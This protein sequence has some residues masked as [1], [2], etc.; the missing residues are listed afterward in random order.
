M[1]NKKAVGIIGMGY[2]V[3]EKILTNQDLEKIVDTSNEWIVERTGVKER[4]IA[5]ENEATSDLAIKASLEALKNANVLADELDLVIVA[6]ATQDMAFPSVACLVQNAIGAKRAAAFDLTAGC[7]GFVY[8][9]VTASQFIQNGLYK[10]ILI[11]GS[12]TLSKITNWEDRNTCVLF[13]DGA[14]A[15]VVSEVDEG[16][17]LLGCELGANGGGGDLLKLPAGGSR[18]PAS[19]ETI[20]NK[21]HYIHMDGNEV[22]KFAIKIMGEAALKS[23]ERAGLKPEDID[24]LVPHQANNRIILSAAKKLK[25]PME[26]VLVN[27]ERYGNTS[28]ASIPIVMNEALKD[29][30]IKKGTVLT[31]VGFGAG[32]TWAACTMR[33]AV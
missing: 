8:A 3:P 7:S 12:E 22:F 16:F 28:A 30:R 17:G 4:R 5:S 15:A 25:M 31:L 1:T 23:I 21:E 26:K 29:G 6:T 11:I 32:L 13:G 20:N 14:G 33:W 2:Y 9:F 18:K 24:L 19:Q 27:V 10:K